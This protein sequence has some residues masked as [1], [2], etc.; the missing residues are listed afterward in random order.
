LKFTVRFIQYFDWFNIARGYINS[1]EWGK[2]RKAIINIQNKDNNCFF[3]CIYHYFKRDG[4]RHNR[5]IP[6]DVP[7]TF[8]SERGIDVSMFKDGI[9][10]ETLR[11]FEEIT[12]IGINIFY[13]DERG[14]EY[15]KHDYVS[16]YNDQEYEPTINLGYITQG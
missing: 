6:M 12:K 5:D 8:L 4:K 3:K 9:T 15:T 16:I 14:P 7:N 10:A 1:P 11:F 2:N 13:I